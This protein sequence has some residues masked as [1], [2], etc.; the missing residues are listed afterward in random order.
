VVD[1][2]GVDQFREVDVVEYPT[3]L[4][5]DEEPQRFVRRYRLPGRVHIFP[6]S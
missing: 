2:S 6:R 5:R 4:P 3:A 1:E